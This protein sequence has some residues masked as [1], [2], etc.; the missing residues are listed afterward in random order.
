MNKKQMRDNLEHLF[1][2]KSLRVKDFG[3]L[4]H[5]TEGRESVSSNLDE[6]AKAKLIAVLSEAMEAMFESLS[7]QEGFENIYE[8]LSLNGDEGDKTFLERLEN[9]P[10]FLACVKKH[11]IAIEQ[12]KAESRRRAGLEGDTPA[13]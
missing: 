8:Q 12:A 9:S 3:I 11:R 4:K 1:D 7:K 13:C 10:E 5:F 6:K 2:D